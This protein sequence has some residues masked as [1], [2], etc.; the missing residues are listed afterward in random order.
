MRAIPHILLTAM[1]FQLLSSAWA[2]NGGKWNGSYLNRNSGI[3]L[4]LEQNSNGQYQGEFRYEGLTFPIR[5]NSG[6]AAFSG[7]YLYQEKWFPFSLK[8]YQ[9]AF[10]LTVD[11]VTVPVEKLSS[12]TSTAPTPSKG[13]PPSPSS[14]GKAG[15]AAIEGRENAAWNQR[16]KGRQ[17]IFLET[18]GGGTQKATIYLY[19][20]GRFQYEYSSSYSSGGYAD[21]SYADQDKDQGTWKIVERGGTVFL[22]TVSSKNGQK[23]EMRIQQGASATQVLI[24]G[25][26]FF[27]GET[28]R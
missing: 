10:T 22:M 25:K 15:S 12:S 24:N 2:Q 23:A 14:T 20:D 28:L 17:L 1:I 16:L 5:G 21:F 18:S 7:E 19:P 11:G 13:N 26:R 27:I 3:S 4:K 8:P 9:N 6:S